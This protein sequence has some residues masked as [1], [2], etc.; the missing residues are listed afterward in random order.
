[1]AELTR[2]ARVQADRL[3]HAQDVQEG[4]QVS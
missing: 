4:R 2:Q 3:A 1:L